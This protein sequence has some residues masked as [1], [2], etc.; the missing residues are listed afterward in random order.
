V[1]LL[2][3]DYFPSIPSDRTSL[4]H[5]GH[6]SVDADCFIHKNYEIMYNMDT[7]FENIA[8]ARP[9]C[10]TEARANLL[11]APIESEDGVRSL[12]FSINSAVEN[13]S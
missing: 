3:S 10:M 12:S 4:S 7:A 13:S 6:A 1:A 11:S 5:T 2:F 9:V 8:F